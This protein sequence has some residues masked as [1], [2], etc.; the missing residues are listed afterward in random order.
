[1]R[2]QVCGKKL[3]KTL[4]PIGPK[5]LEK[6]GHKCV[7][8]GHCDIG[9]DIFQDGDGSKKIRTTGNSIKKKE[10]S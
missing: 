7:N 10:T 5:C 3:S 9:Q 6:L 4:G 1:M 2:C 8:S